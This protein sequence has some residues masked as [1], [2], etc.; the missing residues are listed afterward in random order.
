MACSGYYGLI[1]LGQLIRNSPTNHVIT[2]TNLPKSDHHV[3]NVLI[4]HKRQCQ[5]EY[6]RE[7]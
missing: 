4:T 2:G 6:G 3:C 5:W 1:F 7:M